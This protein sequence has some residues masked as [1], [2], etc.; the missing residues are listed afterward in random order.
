[1]IHAEISRQRLFRQ[2]V[3]HPVLQNPTDVVDLLC[4]VQSQD[5]AGA[6]WAVAQR[7]QGTVTDADMDHLFAQGAIL[8]THVLRPTWHF[9]TP[10]DIRWLLALTAPRVQAINATYYRKFNLDRDTLRQSLDVIANALAGGKHLLRS[11]L[12]AALQA[13]G[14]STDDLRLNLLVMNAELEAVICSGPRRGK[15]FTYALLDERA[16]STPPL[17]REEAVA[18]LVLRYFTG[19]GP[20]T[21]K[22]F[23]W[24]SGLTLGDA[25]AGIEAVASDLNQE[26]IDG[27]TYWF[28]EYTP[29]P[30]TATPTAYL[31]PNYDEALA[32]YADR[33]AAV[34]PRFAHMWDRDN[35]IFVHHLVIDGQI[36][37]SWKRTIRTRSAT[38]EYKPFIALTDAEHEAV[39]AAARRFSDFLELPVNV[40]PHPP[41]Y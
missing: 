41:S 15:Q 5:Y 29:L 34:Q 20:A 12:A 23:T 10:A 8:R 30:P 27:E 21:L 18:A 17:P 32:S 40:V 6:K 33:S 35:S 28:A 7:T 1:M 13:A 39:A 19:H 22:D 25:R 14:I 3:S 2:G 31:L 26:T 9:V 24:W 16:P 37:G 11:E 38:V 4:A 36:V